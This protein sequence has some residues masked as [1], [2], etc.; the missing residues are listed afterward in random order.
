MKKFT[1]ILVCLM[2][3]A[4]LAVPAGAEEIQASEPETVHEHSWTTVD[5]ATCENPGTLT[6]SCSCGETDTKD[7]PAKGHAWNA[8][9]ETTKATCQQE[10]V[11][12]YTCG[13]CGTT[14]TDS[15]PIKT[16]HAFTAWEKTATTHSRACTDCGQQENGSHILT[17]EITR[18]P[19]CKEDGAKKVTC[20]VCGYTETVLLVKLTTHTYDSACDAECNVCGTKR[21]TQHSFTT[22]WSKDYSGHWHECTKCGEKKDQ[23]NHKAGGAAT[24]ESDQ[25]CLTCNYVIA[26]KKE[27]VHDYG[28]EWA[29]DEVG[30]WHACA[31]CR[32]EK[33]YASHI[34]D[35]AC[36]GDCNTCGYKRSDSHKYDTEGWNT[37]KFDHWNI[38]AVCHEE[39]KKEKHIAGP[40]ATAE[41]AQTCKV[42]GYEIAPKLEHTHDFGSVYTVTEDSHWKTCDCGD[43]SVP[44]PHSWDKGRASK[45]DTVTYRCTLCDA[46]KVVKAPASF[47]WL[48]VI[49]VVLAL[50]CIGGI[51]FLVIMLKRGT[52]DEE[53]EETEEEILKEEDM[54]PEVDEEEL[55]IDEFFASLDDKQ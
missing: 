39:S 15:I 29:S 13:T 30:H 14:K 36:D 51:V 3:F 24:E 8:G 53:P 47:P 10:G 48:T 1:S 2:L 54:I 28:E 4:T 34:Y 52:F 9:V 16:I 41:A 23:E 43:T 35:D 42:C 46:E 33:D 17:E 27:H 37:T 31:K 21:Q 20:S 22:T 12:T 38:C 49:L 5:S 7:S 18:K 32:E 44:E 11:L 40:A 45:N 55:A 19:S 50:G 6:T 26:K 25:L